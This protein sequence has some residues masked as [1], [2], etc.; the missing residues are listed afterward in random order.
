MLLVATKAGVR[1]RGKKIAIGEAFEANRRDAK[2]LVVI[3][4][5][6]VAPEGSVAK[7][8]N[9]AL[10]AE[11]KISERTGR[12]VRTYRRRDITSE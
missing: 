6:V 12:P 4:H 5:A 3:G 1:Y 11:P 9:R 7:P 2:V 8:E 10:V